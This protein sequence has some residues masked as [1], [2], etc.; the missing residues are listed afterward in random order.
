MHQSGFIQGRAIADNVLITHEM[1]HFLKT[2]QATKRCS[3]VVKIDMSKAYDRIEWGFL[4]A[5]LEILDFQETW[6]DWIMECITM[7]SY[8]FL[9]NGTPNGRVLPTRGLRQGDPLSPYIF[10]L[11]TEVL[12]G[13]FQKAH[14]FGKLKGIQVARKGHTSTTCCLRMTLCPLDAQARVVLRNYP[15][16]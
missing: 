1:L 6:I 11:C 2:S 5:V 7:V 4:R 13:L 16:F 3:M 8:S 9:I 15:T 10:I 12:S 14:T